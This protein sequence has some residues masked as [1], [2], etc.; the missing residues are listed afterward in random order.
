M[1][2]KRRRTGR[3][4]EFLTCECINVTSLETQLDAIIRSKADIVFFQ[5][6]KVKKQ[7]YKRFKADLKEAGWRIHLSP[8]YEGG[9]KPSGGV[10]VIWRADKVHVHPERL[11][12]PELI[13]AR[14]RGMVERYIIDVGWEHAYSLYNVYG[15]SGGRTSDIATTEAMLLACRRDMRLGCFY[16]TL[17]CGVELKSPHMRVE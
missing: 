7:D 2:R 1:I 12:D 4:A 8:A 13:E 15:K 6:H 9:K 5:E 16:S 10:G 17:M 3:T 14:G 11:K